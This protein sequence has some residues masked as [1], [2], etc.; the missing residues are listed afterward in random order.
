MATELEINTLT[1]AF[2][3]WVWLLLIFI[4]LSLIFAVYYFRKQF[5]LLSRVVSN[6]YQVNENCEQDSLEFFEKAWP[7]L[8]S[9]GCLGM[10]AS[11]EWFGEHKQV[12][13]GLVPIQAYS[14]KLTH[15]VGVDDMRFEMTIA[16]SRE[17]SQPESIANVVTQTFLH[18][19][20]QDLTVKQSEILT[21]QK[22]LE[23]YQ[24]FVQHE[25][26][27]IAQFINLLSEQLAL[28]DTDDK[29]LKL[30]ERIK[31]TMPVMAVRAKNTIDQMQQPLTELF[32][33]QQLEVE[34]LIDEI[35]DMYALDATIEGVAVTTLPKQILLEVLKNILGNY[36]DHNLSSGK[37]MIVIQ[38]FDS[39]EV[40]I[41]I[42]SHQPEQGCLQTERM[43]EPFWSTSDSGMGLG[44]FLAR[45]LLKQVNGKVHFF[46]DIENKYDGFELS[47]P[48]SL[49]K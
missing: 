47:F 29:K 20:E 22:R 45:E 6:L 41:V 38:S 7:E 46:Q 12:V 15:A 11:I 13:R 18:I 43:F 31:T 34:K 26:K 40:G 48:V 25:I 9:V 39:C 1:W 17:A 23:R 19:L 32:E 10:T 4:G 8:E 5:K 21:S 3:E 16:V 14:H 2:A 30:V 44:L 35:V 49:D 33:F 36:R 27:N 24:L 28:V 37:V 42:K